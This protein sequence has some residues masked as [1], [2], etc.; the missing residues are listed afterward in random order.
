MFNIMLLKLVQF[1]EIEFGKR[2]IE[3]FVHPRY[4]KFTTVL[5]KRFIGGQFYVL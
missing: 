2:I 3:N 1:I 5:G 4:L